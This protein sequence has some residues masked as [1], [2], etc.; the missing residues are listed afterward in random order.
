MSSSRSDNVLAA[1]AEVFAADE[2]APES[3]FE[4]LGSTSVLFLRLLVFLQRHLDADI[5]VVDMYSVET[6][7]DLIQLV[8]ERTTSGSTTA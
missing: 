5:D 3:T 1:V 2:V 8:D 4:D 6:V 7:A